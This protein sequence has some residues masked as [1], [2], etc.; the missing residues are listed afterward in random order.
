MKR[1]VKIVLV[2]S[3]ALNIVVIGLQLYVKNL[4]HEF[5]AVKEVDVKLEKDK[6]LSL[7]YSKYPETK[8]KKYLFI[9]IWETDSGT[10]MEQMMIIDSIMDPRQQDYACV[11]L[12]P[13]KND[14]ANKILKQQKIKTKNFVYLHEMEDIIIALHQDKNVKLKNITDIKAPLNVIIDKAGKILFWQKHFWITGLTE[15]DLKKNPRNKFGYNNDKQ[16]IKS[17]DSI[18]VALK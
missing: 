15:E 11:F 18:F 17:L 12:C 5:N 2:A 7:L 6:F 4:T 8:S 13:E 16:F 9:Q 3:L 14:Y 10:G 1:W